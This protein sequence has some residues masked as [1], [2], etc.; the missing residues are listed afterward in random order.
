MALLQQ[1]TRAPS[2]ASCADSPATTAE[3]PSAS[4]RIGGLKLRFVQTLAL[5]F[6]TLICVGCGASTHRGT[7]A[8][9]VQ[10]LPPLTDDQYLDALRAYHALSPNSPE[11]L[12]RRNQLVAYLSGR[13]DAVVS[14]ADYAALLQHFGEM[15]R[16]LGPEDFGGTLPAG[17]GNACRAVVEAGSP[18]GDEGAV[19]SALK[20]LLITDGTDDEMRADYESE[21]ELVDNWGRGVRGQI[22]SEVERYK[23]LIDVWQ[24]HAEYAPAPEVLA[25]LA[26]LLIKRRDAI[27]QMMSGDQRFA[28]DSMNFFHLRDADLML[29]RAPLD[30]AAIFLRHGQLDEAIQKV[31]SMG[32]ASG[33]EF[34]LVKLLR[35]AKDGD[36]SALLELAATYTDGLPSVTLGLCRT[37]FRRSPEN[38]QFPVCMA[39]A[40]AAL[41]DYPT[42]TAWYAEAISLAPEQRELYDEALDKLRMFLERGWFEANPSASRAMAAQA[43]HILDERT[44]RWPNSEPAVTSER[45]Q[46]VIGMLELNQG[47]P[48]EAE[49]RFKRSIEANPSAEAWLQL[50]RVAETTGRPNEAAEHYQK[51]LDMTEGGRGGA[52]LAQAELLEHLGNALR[53]D[54]KSPEAKSKYAQAL[55]LWDKA[56]ARINDAGLADVNVRRGVL[57]SRIGQGAEAAKAFADAMVAGPGRRDIYARILSHLVSAQLDSESSRAA[58]A[59]QVFNEA[60]N[61]TTLEPEWKVYFALWLK[62]VTPPA[63]PTSNE[64]IDTV[65]RENSDDSWSGQLARFGRGEIDFDAL[66]GKA[67]NIG[68]RAE[69]YFYEATR[70]LVAGDR[71]G[72]ERMLG[73]VLETHMINFYE[74]TMATELL[75]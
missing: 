59:E 1:H 51:A 11:H 14:Q 49:R 20:I 23:G 54:G 21:Y 18:R 57:L 32:D 69:A 74:Y 17:F 58:L 10:A 37:G 19:M 70:R 15:T 45:L 46:Y 56:K 48:A 50:G 13:T 64:H 68:E 44:Q 72:A 41:D 7:T 5:A 75:R 27:A 24:V 66:F 39:H 61:Q 26:D 29:R 30:V 67:T 28:R 8:A 31:E 65:L 35:A 71:E 38:P 4:A 3:R 52:S 63:E 25:F 12:A 34:Q 9:G 36:D 40:H 16:L 43:E 62:A 73:Q 22:P 53:A 2:S 60:Q 42:A 6:V 55:T 33:I 47:N